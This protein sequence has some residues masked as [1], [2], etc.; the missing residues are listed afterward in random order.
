MERE[1]LIP[2]YT[3][4]YKAGTANIRMGLISGVQS[5]ISVACESA[6]AED[7]AVGVLITNVGEID[8]TYCPMVSYR[9]GIRFTYKYNNTFYVIV[10]RACLVTDNLIQ[11]ISPGLLKCNT[12]SPYNIIDTINN[13]VELGSIDYHGQI[14]FKGLAPEAV[15]KW[16][17]IIQGKYCQ[18]IDTG[19][20]LPTQTTTA[21][22]ILPGTAIPIKISS[23]IMGKTD[24]SVDVYYDDIYWRSAPSFGGYTTAP[25]YAIPSKVDLLY[26]SDITLP[27]AMG[28]TYPGNF[29]AKT[30]D[31]TLF[32]ER[33]KLDYTGAYHE[34]DGYQ[35]G[36]N[37]SG[38]YD[39]F[40]LFGQIY[41][42]DGLN[43]Y[44]ASFNGTAFQSREMACP[45]YGMTYIAS[46]PTQI[47]FLSSYDNSLY[48]FDGG[49]SLTKYHRLSDEA[50]VTDGV[51]STLENTLLLQTATTFIWVRDNVI[52]VNAKKT[53]QTA[54][55]LY[56]TSAGIVISNNV[57][58]WI[59]S[60]LPLA[61]STVVPF[62]YF[63][64]YLG[65]G[66]EMRAATVTYFATLYSPTKAAAD[67]TLVC[68]SFDEDG[69]HVQTEYLHIN[70][71]DWASNGFYR[72]RIQPQSQ[73][74]VAAAIGVAFTTKLILNRVSVEYAAD[75]AVVT[76]AARSR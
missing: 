67:L 58:K 31:E 75:E 23:A 64:P 72:C 48:V 76:S 37:L 46:A 25:A 41:L 45:A 12:I 65:M 8:N 56:T 11:E 15:H 19:D 47:Y 16:A 26:V 18:S 55:A 66:T 33:Y 40:T 34:F 28:S 22:P 57:N 68:Y 38:V 5:F 27:V 69:Y 43:I 63:G 59:Y 2:Q 1:V 21:A 14:K 36:N 54:T 6:A 53:N 10:L 7:D 61:G 71:G 17:A 49:R 60:Y 24:Y 30:K 44:A 35:I 73:K 74:A 29:T 9:Y 4:A 42:F 39:S 50:T 32:L 51:Y 70:A 52:S 62:V 20:K 3:G 13:K